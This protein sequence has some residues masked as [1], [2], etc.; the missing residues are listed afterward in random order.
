MKMITEELQQPE[1]EKPLLTIAIPTYNRARYLRENLAALF[2]QLVAEPRVELIVSD[3]ASLDE[4]PLLVREFQ[5]RGLGICYIRND[6]NLGADKNI[7]QCFEQACGK[8]VWI[9]GDDDIVLTGCVK[10]IMVYLE[11]DDYDMLYLVPY[12]FDNDPLAEFLP[13][14]L[15]REVAVIDSA[16]L[17][18]KKIGTMFSLISCNILN[19]ERLLTIEHQPFIKFT[20]TNLIQLSWTYPLLTRFSKGLCVYHRFLAIR[21][22]TSGGYSV[23]RVFGEN[24]RYVTDELLVDHPSLAKLIYCSAITGFLPFAILKIR[25]NR[26]GA[27]EIEDFHKTLRFVYG[28]YYQ[29]WLYVFPVAKSPLWLAWVWFV[30]VRKVNYVKS[31]LRFLYFSVNRMMRVV[32][33]AR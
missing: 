23:T 29:Y 27:F 1:N 11:M 9:I 6:T 31:V 17:F 3:N 8:Y 26:H 30:L 13:D 10:Q 2:D 32:C 28:N 22:G 5:E 33:A 19:K 7:L 12:G 24:L 20:G 4:T 18:V 21:N 15:G 14:P 25:Q 16:D